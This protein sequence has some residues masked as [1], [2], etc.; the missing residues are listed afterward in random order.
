[1]TPDLIKYS[2]LVIYFVYNTFTVGDIYHSVSHSSFVGAVGS[3]QWRIKQ[4][5]AAASEAANHQC[6]QGVKSIML[7]MFPTLFS[8][9]S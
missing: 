8:N 9:A 3:L 1:M 4:I 2:H 5:F 6:R 7:I